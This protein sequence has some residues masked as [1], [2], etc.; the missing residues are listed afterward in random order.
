[1][2]RG[3]LLIL[4]VWLCT[5]FLATSAH[6]TCGAESCPLV[7]DGLHGPGRF[8]VDVRLQEA[9]QDQLWDGTAKTTLDDVM[10]GAEPDGEVELYTRTRTLIAE[11]RLRLTDRLSVFATLPYMDREHR[12]AIA[13]TTTFDPASVDTWTYRGLA[14]AT[15]LGQFHVLGSHHGPSV[16]LQ[17]GAKLPTGRAHVDGEVRDN[18]GVESALEPAARPGTG[19]LDGIAG[20]YLSHPL[21]VKGLSPLAV[22]VQQR[23]MG[24]G[25]DDYRVGDEL[26]AGV[27]TGLALHDRVTL[28][29]QLNYAK[30][31]ADVSADA[32]EASH[33]AIEAFFVTPGVR[34]ELG[35]GLSAYGMLQLR[36]WTK[37]E[38]ATVVAPRHLMLGLTW[39]ALE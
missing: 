21:P 11:A 32:T 5:S 10:A 27:A 34:V 29:A 13:H 14:D 20:V 28:L 9:T 39:A 6:A 38:E 19:S 3:S 4:S 23:W 25:T 31:G 7:R 2:K 33:S 17:V 15:V 8:A 37:S 36:A 16:M 26:H 24:K 35:A 12:H 1:M 30:H 18:A 22:T